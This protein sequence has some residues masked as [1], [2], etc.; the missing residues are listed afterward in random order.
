MRVF[1]SETQTSE[2]EN[3]QMMGIKPTGKKVRNESFILGG[4]F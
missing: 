4:F 2:G 1:Y 3:Q